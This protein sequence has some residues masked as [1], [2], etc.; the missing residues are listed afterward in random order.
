MAMSRKQRRELICGLAFL[1]PNILGFLL[2]GLVPLVFSLALAFSNWDLRFHNMFKNEPLR[3]VGFGNFVRLMTL[4]DFWR[5][6]ANTLFFMMAIPFSVA[7]SLIL[8]LMLS[9]DLRGGSARAFGLLFGGV[10]LA[11][12]IV[13]LAALGAPRSSMFI[14][15]TGLGCAILVFG[16]L[17]ATTFY[18]TLFYLPH[19]CAGVATYIL[20]KKLYNPHA[21]PINSVLAA[22][23]KAV[24]AAVNGSPPG[25]VRF[26]LWACFAVMAWLL[27]WGLRRMRRMWLDGDLG[28]SAAIAPLALLLAP[29][30]AA[31]KWSPLKAPALAVAAAALGTLG[32]QVARARKGR[33]FPCAPGEGLGNALLL[34]LALMIGEFMLL[35]LGCVFHRLPAMAADGLNPPEWISSYSWAKPALMIMAL[36]GAVGSNNMLLYIAGLSNIPLELYEAADIDGASP[37]QRFWNVTWPQLAPTTFFILVMATIQGLSGG[38]E[39]A[40]TMTLGGPAGSTTFLSYFIYTQGFETGRLGFSSAVAWTLFAMTLALTLINWRFGNRYVND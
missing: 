36:W 22:P 23:L 3:F 21:G 25:L 39:I 38:F 26:G 14:V 20:W 15:L 28:W 19:F 8:A 13:M 32:W 30:A 5:Y 35:G 12:C 37:F 7:G 10:A 33:D 6:L 9:R 31:V 16:A 2:F 17:G 29:A 24:S 34:S 1:T 11:A 27:I 18:R 40:R 4:P